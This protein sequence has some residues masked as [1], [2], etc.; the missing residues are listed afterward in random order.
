MRV[1]RV[2]N[3]RGEGRG[4]RRMMVKSPLGD[5]DL[6]DGLPRCRFEMLD[7]VVGWMRR[8]WEGRY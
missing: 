7:G 3:G 5:L 1:V 4:E 6:I 8:E 2:Y